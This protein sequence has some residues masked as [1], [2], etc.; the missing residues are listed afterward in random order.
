MRRIYLRR[1]STR[2]KVAVA[3]AIACGVSAFLLVRGYEARLAALRPV[4]G[5]PVPIVVAATSLSRGAVLSEDALQVTS[6]PSAFAPPGAIRSIPA[7]IG[8]TLASDL[9]EGEALTRTRIRT[10]GGPV[11]SQVPSGLR[12]FVVPSGMPAGSVRPGDRVD[13]LATF[14]GQRPYT[15]TVATDLEVLSVLASQEGALAVGTDA[16]PSLVLLVAPDAA[17]RLAHAKAFGTLTL[18]IAGA[19]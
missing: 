3:L 10:A 2:S 12:A 19:G 8:A 7:A 5:R 6:V 1:W 11:A 9:A 4:T 18:T 14:G 15:D 13:V 17:E 16:G